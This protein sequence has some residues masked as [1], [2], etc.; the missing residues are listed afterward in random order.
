[1]VKKNDETMQK[2]L[3]YFISE[4]YKIIYSENRWISVIDIASKLKIH[5]SQNLLPNKKAFTIAR[6]I[7]KHLKQD[8][9]NHATIKYKKGY[10]YWVAPTHIGIEELPQTAFDLY[11]FYDRVKYN[12]RVCDKNLYASPEERFKLITHN[13]FVNNYLYKIREPLFE[14]EIIFFPNIVLVNEEHKCK[15]DEPMIYLDKYSSDFRTPDCESCYKLHPD[16]F[17]ECIKC[18]KQRHIYT[19]PKKKR[20]NSKRSLP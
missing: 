5:R 3:D 9:I 19:F 18:C 11:M 4:I 7:D 12:G 1:M 20:K 15:Y 14:D 8:Y 16:Y 6:I 13:I 17:N 2:L 10:D